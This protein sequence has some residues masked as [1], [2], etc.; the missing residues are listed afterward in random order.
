MESVGGAG[1]SVGGDRIRIVESYQAFRSTGLDVRVVRSALGTVPNAFLLGLELVVLRDSESLTRRER[2][3]KVKSRSGRVRK[4]SLRG[5]YYGRSKLSGARIELIMDRLLGAWPEWMARIP[6]FR[7]MMIAR[8]LFHEV[9]HHIQQS[10][11]IP[12]SEE[13]AADQWSEEFTR[14]FLRRQYW[15]LQPFLWVL[16]PIA[17]GGL[18]VLRRLR[19]HR[20]AAA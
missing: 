13:K 2:N 20:S 8:I 12:G 16:L 4:T 1:H 11:R 15:Y 18:Q 7:S 6:F 17:R 14:R 5:V 9:G 19:S 10:R 3:Q